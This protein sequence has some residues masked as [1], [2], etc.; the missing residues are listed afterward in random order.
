MKPA[1]AA[2]FCISGNGVLEIAEHDIDLADHF[3]ARGAELVV[4]RGDEMDH[5]LEADGER[6]ERSGAPIASGA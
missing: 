4:L 3:L 1:R 5:A 6:A 2:S